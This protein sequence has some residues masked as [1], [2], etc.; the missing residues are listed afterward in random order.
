MVSPGRMEAGTA[1]M[2]V[3]SWRLRAVTSLGSGA[4]RSPSGCATAL[5]GEWGS[6]TMPDPIG[7]Y[8]LPVGGRGAPPP[9]D[10]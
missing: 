3:V 2:E 4:G 8:S 5:R 10:V 7:A 1:V 9:E 6:S